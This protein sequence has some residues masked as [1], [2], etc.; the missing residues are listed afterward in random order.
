MSGI[1]HQLEVDRFSKGLRVVWSGAE[2]WCLRE[3]SAEGLKI[4]KEEERD[5]GNGSRDG[6]VQTKAGSE[7]LARL[8]N[9]IPGTSTQSPSQKFLNHTPQKLL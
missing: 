8:V 7:A 4:A 5:S 1:R 9:P 3:T 2:G 6:S